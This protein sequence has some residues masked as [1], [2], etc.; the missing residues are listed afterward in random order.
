MQ[1]SGIFLQSV[2][3]KRFSTIGRF[4]RTRKASFLMDKRIESNNK[5]GNLADMQDG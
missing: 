4:S 2:F 3:F 5:F 1:L